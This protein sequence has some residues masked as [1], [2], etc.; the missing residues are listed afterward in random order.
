[1]FRRIMQLD[2]DFTI[3]I[4]VLGIYTGRAERAI[5]IVIP[6]DVIIW[7]GYTS[8]YPATVRAGIRQNPAII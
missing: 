4:A 7:R 5:P 2:I 6:D 1:M 8:N 3:K